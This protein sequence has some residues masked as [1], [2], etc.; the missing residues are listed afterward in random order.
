MRADKPETN[1]QIKWENYEKLIPAFSFKYSYKFKLRVS[2][3]LL[4]DVE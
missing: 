2:T 4:P 3:P 1:K